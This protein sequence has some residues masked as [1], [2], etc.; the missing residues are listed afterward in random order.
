MDWRHFS[1]LKQYSLT[2]TGLVG[3]QVPCLISR[4]P[5]NS[6]LA[7]F[8]SLGFPFNLRRQT[9]DEHFSFSPE[10][11]KEGRYHTVVTN[12]FHHAGDLLGA[13]VDTVFFINGGILRNFQTPKFFLLTFQVSRTAPRHR[14]KFPQPLTYFHVI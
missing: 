2:L 14:V 3:L 12:L 7:S 11:L 13:A 5:R 9:L 8:Q 10:N 1:D 6:S 4:A